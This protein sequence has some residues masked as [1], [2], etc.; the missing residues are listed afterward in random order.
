MCPSEY[1]LAFPYLRDVLIKI[2]LVVTVVL[3]FSLHT[4]MP[5]WA[6]RPHHSIVDPNYG[7][8]RAS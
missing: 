4:N 7:I 3:F 1:N 5:I 8:S 6:A 2:F